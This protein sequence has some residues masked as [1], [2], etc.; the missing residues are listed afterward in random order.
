MASELTRAVFE[1]LSEDRPV[2]A[3][4]AAY[5]LRNDF[6]PSVLSSETEQS[7]DWLKRCGYART[8]GDNGFGL[9]YLRVRRG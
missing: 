9:E 5:L 2:T 3:V 7:L 8:N 4:G 1:L 6:A